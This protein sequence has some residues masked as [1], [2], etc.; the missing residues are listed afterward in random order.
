MTISSLTFRPR[1]AARPLRQLFSF[2]LVLLLIVLAWETLKWV[3][4]D[5]WRPDA[6]PFGIAHDPPY[7][8]K[9]ASDLNLP[10]VWDIAAAFGNPSR[11]NGPPLAAVLFDAA[12]FTFREAIVGFLFGSLLGFAL[13]TLFAHVSLLERGCMPYVVASQT[14]PIL[15]I[16][17]M[18]IIWLKAGWVSVAVI[19]TYL[20]FF[21]VTINTLRGL[22]SP[23]PMALELMRSYAASD[24]A[25]L[26]KLRF[27]AALPYIFTALK[28]S[29]TASV[30]GAIIGELPS[31]IRDGLGGAILNFNSYY[32]SG[33]GRLWAAIIASAAVGIAFY[34]VVT[35]AEK[36]VLRGRQPVSS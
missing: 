25:I 8:F 36:I 14:I 33:P 18:V 27:P 28:I 34:L 19:A 17:P 26:W 7:R 16:A 31:G 15:A 12:L 9:I 6:N 30:V 1:A 21:P 22:R 10:H 24:W 4:G 13:G 32:I 5:P 11:R 23:D 2:L 20:T 35:F 29:A 3:G